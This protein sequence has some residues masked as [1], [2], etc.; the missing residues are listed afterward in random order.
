M[1]KPA[2]E[3]PDAASDDLP[4]ADPA[5]ERYVR[6]SLV[7]LAL[8]GGGIRSATFALGV[9]Q[10]FGERN[11]LWIFDYLSTVS[12][13]GFAGAWW[14]AWL[15]RD[16][17]SPG[18]RLFPLDERLEPDRF[19]A[20]FLEGAT[21]PP[22]DVP[23]ATPEGSRSALR[24]D[25]IHHL[26]LFSNYLTPRK[27][28]LSGDTWR[29]AT[30]ISR[31][32]VLTWMVLLPLLVAAMLAAQL[33][34]AGN[35]EVAYDFICSRPDSISLDTTW[36]VQLVDSTR[37][38]VLLTHRTRH[39][40]PDQSAVCTNMA[41]AQARAAGAAAAPQSFRPPA[42]P[43]A[44]PVRRLASHDD[45]FRRRLDVL[46]D[47]LFAAVLVLGAFVLLWM[48]Y[49]SG[50]ILPTLLGCVVALGSLG[51]VLVEIRS[52]SKGETGGDAHGWDHFLND[53]WF[54]AAAVLVLL[55][56]VGGFLGAPAIYRAGGEVRVAK[57]RVRNLVVRWHARTLATM[58]VVLLVLA[59]AGF[60]H[61]LYWFLF[62][63]AS[64]AVPA[65]LH[66]AGGWTALAVTIGT[67]LFTILRAGPSARGKDAAAAAP[68]M[69]TQLAIT[70]APVLVLITLAVA[71]ATLGR[72]L[73]ATYTTWDPS[74]TGGASERT[75]IVG[76][77]LLGLGLLAA[78]ALY[79]RWVQ[80][81]RDPAS[82]SGPPL[83]AR[84]AVLAA[85][86]AAAA[87]PLFASAVGS[88]WVADPSL[89]LV[90]AALIVIGATH[91]LLLGTTRSADK[92]AMVSRGRGWGF[93]V[94]TILVGEIAIAWW[95]KVLHPD[96]TI[97]PPG[98]SP[99]PEV[100]FAGIL[101]SLAF[102]VV[103]LATRHTDSDR[104]VVLSGIVA[105][106]SGALLVL[107]HLPH[108]SVA[109]A[110]A[111]LGVGVLVLLLSTVIGLGW[112]ADPN[113]IALH[114]FYKAR[115]VR[116]Y[117]GASNTD[118]KTAEITE[119]VATDDL[120]LKNVT[121][122]KVGGP[123]H[124]I[125]TTL[126][127]VG[128]RDLSTAQRYAAPFTMSSVI[129]GSARTGYRRTEDYMSGTLS[130]GAAVAAS[131]AAVSTN[132]G[133]KTMSA[134]LTLLLALFNVRLGLWVPT[135]NR[136]RWYEAQPRLWPF[137][138]LREALSQTNALGTYCYLTDGAHF[139][140]TGLYALVERGCRYVIVL[141]D[142]ADER[143]C[144]SDMGDAIRRCRIDFGAEVALASGINVFVQTKNGGM[145]R[146]HHA[147][148][149]I[150]YAVPHLK[151]LGWSDNEI[152]QK[153]DGTIIWIK[154]AITRTDSVDVQQYK[155]ENAA[156]PQQTTVDQWYDEA[157]FESYRALGYQAVA[158]RL[159][160][161]LA[162]MQGRLGHAFRAPG[163][164]AHIDAFFR[165]F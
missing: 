162:Q 112:M 70:V 121:N 165:D 68:G 95:M 153:R 140:N 154:P 88:R 1:T 132:M 17:Q 138:L 149:T 62:E 67:G 40:R 29:A 60:G 76:A 77:A 147:R 164:F 33:Y 114:D 32:L 87:L 18:P 78:F 46:L 96:P 93:L 118:R 39:A 41:A 79:E 58:S 45:V 72:W 31:N 157:Q 102:G 161:L 106:S 25:P 44:A 139:D 129:C 82:G 75:H 57:D 155:L 54:V 150:R 135:P 117:L 130:L 86:A 81:S 71:A 100:A 145:A 11:L 99:V 48:L 104:S 97:A 85:P 124:I 42:T 49:G 53:N 128:G 152:A 101:F 10:A 159:D 73:F 122:H 47:P 84:V 20:V 51:W 8:S 110:F 3:H 5:D 123:V 4:P 43:S 26:R 80:D 116:A 14:S 148:G 55:V 131:G 56:V 13:G 136:G 52:P 133:S 156:F 38:P 158:P 160:T 65:A 146:V 36:R 34:F 115:L 64:G 30:V 89:R 50:P 16:G 109:T 143:P 19:P 12:G 74:A 113:L 83:W 98:D 27:G 120:P 69:L 125:S 59:V 66:K 127:L 151:M 90:F 107:H 61:E 105:L 142:G 7:G 6:T 126:N 2:A 22:T 134:A 94:V 63:P 92:R 24:Q 37:V 21:A 103:N 141:D 163:D 119:T 144:F 9:L 111:I 137:Y 15:S 28:I 108:A 35:D 91:A 23:D